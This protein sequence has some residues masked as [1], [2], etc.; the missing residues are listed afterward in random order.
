MDH[1]RGG[2][3]ACV[4]ACVSACVRAGGRA[5]S[6]N[7]VS[8]RITVRPGSSFF[9]H[10]V[11]PFEPSPSWK[12]GAAT[13]SNGTNTTPYVATT[14]CW[15]TLRVVAPALVLHRVKAPCNIYGYTFSRLDKKN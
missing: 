12:V 1:R 4:R 9:E 2:G 10:G 15:T 5:C 11:S 7:R 14:D 6:D 8:I 3:S 13:R